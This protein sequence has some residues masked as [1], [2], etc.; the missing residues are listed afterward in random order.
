M[1]T[2]TSEIP[3]EN[4]SLIHIQNLLA[5]SELSGNEIW[6]STNANRPDPVTI[7]FDLENENIVVSFI[8]FPDEKDELISIKDYT[9]ILSCF[10]LS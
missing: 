4:L 7:S 8:E 1:Y 3:E 5:A 2:F 10:M 6:Y 9:Y